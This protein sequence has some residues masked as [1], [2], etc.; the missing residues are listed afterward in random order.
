MAQLLVRQVE[1]SLVQLLKHRAAEHGCSAEE[2]HRRILREALVGGS[3][4]GKMSLKDYLIA[5]PH[6]DGE[7]LPFR[8]HPSER[9]V[10]F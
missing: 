10:D 2:E 8:N 3:P 4:G 1:D 6:V 9:T 5:E 7:W